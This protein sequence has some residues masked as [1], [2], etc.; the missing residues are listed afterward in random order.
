MHLNY[1]RVSKTKN[2]IFFSIERHFEG[3]EIFK[4]GCKGSSKSKGRKS[5][6]SGTEKEN[7][8]TIAYQ[9]L[10]AEAISKN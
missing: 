7:F 4:S 9:K 8:M 2:A 6:S 1:I 5:A 3:F 10:L